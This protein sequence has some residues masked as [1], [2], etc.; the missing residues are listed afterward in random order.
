MTCEGWVHRPIHTVFLEW[1]IDLYKT[2]LPPCVSRDLFVVL[3]IKGGKTGIGDNIISY[4]STAEGVI[5]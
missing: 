1:W 4:Y 3:K 5:V 2:A